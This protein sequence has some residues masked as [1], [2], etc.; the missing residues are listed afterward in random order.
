[1]VRNPWVDIARMKKACW[2][3]LQ[4]P[5]EPSTLSAAWLETF[6][7]TY[8]NAEVLIAWSLMKKLG[9]ARLLRR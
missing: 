2:L 4:F 1:V 8:I 5:G 7:D 3:A 9:S 6:S